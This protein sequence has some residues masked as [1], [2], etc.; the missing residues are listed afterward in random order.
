MGDNVTA[1]VTAALSQSNFWQLDLTTILQ[2]AGVIIAVITLIV[3]YFVPISVSKQQAKNEKIKHHFDQVVQNV[4]IPIATVI[5]GLHPV[6][7]YI[8]T[9]GIPRRTMEEASEN[10]FPATF[11]FEGT[12]EYKSIQAHY[13]EILQLWEKLV[14]KTLIHNK[15]MDKFT[16]DL[17]DTIISI[18]QEPL[19]AFRPGRTG[20]GISVISMLREAIFS[21]VQG[22]SLINDFNRIRIDVTGDVGEERYTLYLE[23][24]L[25]AGNSSK[26]VAESYKRQL[27][28]T[29]NSDKLLKEVSYIISQAEHIRKEFESLYEEC[30]HIVTYGLLSNN[31]EYKFRKNSKCPICKE[32]F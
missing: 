16:D 25:I 24:T 11:N 18:A 1:N 15:G 10:P 29:Q 26:Q 13:P 4:I 28:E 14:N 32:I 31:A 9:T 8:E 27:I 5:N 19:V 12:K 22:L 21:R 17:K 2:V 30:S 23:S 7:G 3:L 6:N 20:I